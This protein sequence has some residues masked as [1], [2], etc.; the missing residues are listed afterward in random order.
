MIK[1]VH[2]SLTVHENSQVLKIDN[3]S[4]IQNVISP[5]PFPPSPQP[6]A[7]LWRI[8]YKNIYE[9][10]PLHSIYQQQKNNIFRSNFAT[11]AAKNSQTFDKNHEHPEV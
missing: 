3:F 9:T 4:E 11:F 2:D 1:Q 7:S 8:V 6:P 5:P 10:Q